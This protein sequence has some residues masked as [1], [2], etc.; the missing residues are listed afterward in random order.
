MKCHQI[1]YTH[2]SFDESDQK[3]VC[4]VFSQPLITR[5]SKVQELE[6]Q[7]AQ[8]CTSTYCVLFSS[9]T[10]AL[11][12]AGY[13]VNISEK[14][15]LITSPN[16]FVGTVSGALQKKPAFELLDIDPQTKGISLKN[17][18]PKNKYSRQVLMP[19]HFSGVAEIP[20]HS[21][22]NAIVI[23]DACQAFGA[24]YETGEPVGGC[25]YS[26]LTVFSFHPAKTLCM[27]EGGCVTT[28]N[29]DYY[30]RLVQ[31]RN[32]GITKLNSKEPWMY[33]VND[34][35]TN[36]NV[37]EFSA[38]LGLSQLKRL[39]SFLMQR[40]KLVQLYRQNLMN[41]PF[42]SLPNASY[43]EKSAHNLFVVE[44]DFQAAQVSRAE[45]MNALSDK[46][47]GTQV[48]FIP[49]YKQA[50][51]EKHFFFDVKKFP[52][53]ERFYQQALS[54]PLYVDLKKEDVEYISS[55]L[56]ALLCKKTELS[57]C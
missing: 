15:N 10:L 41:A 35:T 56:C 25:Q 51:F 57:Y 50:Y 34:L 46:G 9:G 5:G 31:F 52:E 2:Q 6:K 23:E 54:L 17:Y 48:H 3:A 22:N 38:A 36:A 11:Q 43:D 20:K 37:T 16:T 32:N 49:L 33:Q 14:D 21:L 8:R 28:N 13:A 4:E 24:L 39:D 45:L 53:M 40:K 27:G 29:L 44:I 1:P 7:I 55:T 18:V 30:H 26:D 47:I 42:I 19:V 12:A